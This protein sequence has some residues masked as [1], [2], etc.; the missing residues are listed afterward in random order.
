[1]G[2]DDQKILQCDTSGP[3]SSSQAKAQAS[4]KARK[5][6]EDRQHAQ[7]LAEEEAPGSAPD[8]H[9]PPDM[10][11]ANKEVLSDLTVPQLRDR[12]ISVMEPEVLSGANLRSMRNDPEVGSKHGLLKYAKFCANMDPDFRLQ[13]RFRCFNQLGVEARTRAKQRGNRAK[14]LTLRPEWAEEGLHEIM[15]FTSDE[16]KEVNIRHRFT[17]KEVAVAVEKLPNFKEIDDLWVDFNWS[18]DAACV[19]SKSAKSDSARFCLANL[20]PEQLVNPCTD[21]KNACARDHLKRQFAGAVKASP[22]KA[23]KTECAEHVKQET[24]GA[25][26]LKTECAEPVKQETP[27]APDLKTECAQPVKQET[28][29]VTTSAPAGQQAASAAEGQQILDELSFIPP[30][31]VAKEE[32][33]DS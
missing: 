4:R 13:G 7:I 32:E 17:M 3:E 16:N 9:L 33:P 8:V 22:A 24:P 6:E 27:G 30:A 18:E 23:P 15:G 26:D 5:Q 21:I 19:K 29:V 25:P 2:Y 20:F 31:P 1:M 28:P 10:I 11:P 14:S 12:V